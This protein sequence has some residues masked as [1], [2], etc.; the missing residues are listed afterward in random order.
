MIPLLD[1]EQ[2]KKLHIKAPWHSDKC[3]DALIES[4]SANF[5]GQTFDI[6]FEEDLIRRLTFGHNVILGRVAFCS[7]VLRKNGI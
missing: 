2:T 3:T 7:E 5:A 6:E 1:K 4:G